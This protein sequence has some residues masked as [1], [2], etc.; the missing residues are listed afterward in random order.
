MPRSAATPC[1]APSSI[2]RPLRPSTVPPAP[3]LGQH[4]AQVC[5][6]ILDMPDAEIAALMQEGVLEDDTP[7]PES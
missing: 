6:D 2:F 1:S 5:R 3:L 7:L 4:T